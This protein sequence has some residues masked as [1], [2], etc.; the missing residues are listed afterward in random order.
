[1]D[2]IQLSKEDIDALLGRVK[3]NALQEGDYEIIKSMTEA[4][5][6]L[7]QALDNKATSIKRLLAMLFGPKTEKKD[8]ILKDNEPEEKDK[9]PPKSKPEKKK[10][11]HG[12]VRYW[13][14]IVESLIKSQN[15]KNQYQ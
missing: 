8:E 7:G 15:W 9:K 3:G 12:K 11:G 14:R 10:K 2:Q 13:A 5:M 4:I 6:T 1:M